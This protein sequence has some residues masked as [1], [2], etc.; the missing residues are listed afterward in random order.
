MAWPGGSSMPALMAAATTS[1]WEQP[2]ISSRKS[3]PWRLTRTPR[4]VL[5]WTTAKMF[6]ALGAERADSDRTGKPR[7]RR[8]LAVHGAQRVVEHLYALHRG[9]GEPQVCVDGLGVLEPAHLQDQLRV[10]P[11]QLCHD[12]PPRPSMNHRRRG[13]ILLRQWRT[14]LVRGGLP[15]CA[16]S[17]GAAACGDAAN[18][19]ALRSCRHVG[20]GVDVGEQRAAAALAGGRGLAT[21]AAC[22]GWWCWGRRGDDRRPGRRAAG[23]WSNGTVPVSYW[24]SATR[25]RPT[26]CATSQTA[27][28]T[29]SWSPTSTRTTASTCMACFGPATTAT[30]ARRGRHLSGRVGATGR[31]PTPA[32]DPP[33]GPA[34]TPRRRSSGHGA[35]SPA[36]SRWPPKGWP[37]R[38]WARSM[39]AP[40][41]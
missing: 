13:P 6:G 37:A 24:T 17:G 38:S 1:G 18:R 15:G 7:S 8:T 39:V 14:S 3:A 26:C 19:C 31:R 9:G 12:S 27:G 11:E 2:T 36:R 40:A 32:A 5:W 33:V 23:S 4:G 10:L 41:R 25:R 34:P 30:R 35:P 20:S 22:D 21:S 29:R 28:W 16:G